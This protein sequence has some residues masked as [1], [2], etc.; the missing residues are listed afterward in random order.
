MSRQDE[1]NRLID[2]YNRHLQILKEKKAMQ[3][4]SVETKIIIE[5]EDIETELGKLKAELKETRDEVASS[6]Q[7]NT[8]PFNSDSPDSKELLSRRSLKEFQHL[9]EQ[10]SEWKE[11]HNEFNPAATFPR[12]PA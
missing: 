7:I 10:L 4:S 3:G 5:I 9:H 1:I 12:K 8:S 11:L 2:I 6:P